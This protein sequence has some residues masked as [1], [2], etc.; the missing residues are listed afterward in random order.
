MLLSLRTT[1]PLEGFMVHIPPR[2][3]KYSIFEDSGP[4]SHQ[5]DGY[6]GPESLNIGYLEPLGHIGTL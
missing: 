4:K 6:L 2:G 1:S 5:G 3:S